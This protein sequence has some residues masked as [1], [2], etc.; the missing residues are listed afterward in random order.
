MVFVYV[1]ATLTFLE[2]LRVFM[3]QNPIAPTPSDAIKNVEKVTET[4]NTDQT[5]T[6][7]VELPKPKEAKPTKTPAPKKTGGSGGLTALNA[8]LFAGILTSPLWKPAFYQSSVGQSLSRFWSA[9]ITPTGVGNV[10]ISTGGSLTAESLSATY[11]SRAE[12]QAV[13]DDLNKRLDETDTRLTAVEKQVQNP[14][15]EGGIG[16]IAAAISNLTDNSDAPENT[17]EAT[18][19]PA[20]SLEKLQQDVNM[21]QSSLVL[22]QQKPNAEDALSSLPSYQLQLQA[23][24]RNTETL[25]EI[26]KQVDETLTSID[27]RLEQSSVAGEALRSITTRLD[28]AEVELAALNAVKTEDKKTVA[29]LKAQIGGLKKSIDNQTNYSPER[30]HLAL[31]SSELLVRLAGSEPFEESL[32]IAIAQSRH[33]E[34]AL[35]TVKNLEPYAKTGVKTKAILH[36]EFKDTF[37]DRIYRASQGGS[38][39]SWQDQVRYQLAEVISIRKETA[40]NSSTS[41][42]PTTDILIA[43]DAALEKGD[44][45]A[46]LREANKLK[47]LASKAAEP[48]VDA[49]QARIAVDKI[50]ADLRN[51]LLVIPSEDE[52]E[53]ESGAA[54]KATDTA[55]KSK[56]DIVTL[57]PLFKDTEA[58]KEA[59]TEG[60]KTEPKSDAP[61]EATSHT[62]S[63]PPEH[64]AP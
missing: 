58:S 16:G 44:L 11:P 46:S 24:A 57:E 50:A 48:W 5:N 29:S 32:A 41:G 35:G 63:A 56:D 14:S 49:L 13:Q 33:D 8:L 23:V 34:S 62:D 40:G 20:G 42:D 43:I 9:N 38:G 31:S 61:A 22:L 19:A 54:E 55:D 7:S 25:G 27:S 52:P 45:I 26:K 36:Q 39:E 6:P 53:T 2:T 28:R 1:Y 10:T 15:K 4:V 37:A 3:A 21:L 51:Y 64:S 18:P 60:D 47:G 12:L 30:F 59:L 17:T